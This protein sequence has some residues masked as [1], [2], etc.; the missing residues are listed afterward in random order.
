MI[1]NPLVIIVAILC[2]TVLEIVALL[3]GHNGALFAFVTTLI[4]GTAGWK[5]KQ[6]LAKW[7]EA[8]GW[9][10]DSRKD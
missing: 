9:D 4:A 2:L 8:T 3:L 1:S 10:S 5:G 6:V 7:R